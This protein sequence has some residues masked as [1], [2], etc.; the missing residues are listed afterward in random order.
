MVQVR[1]EVG[2]AVHKGLIVLPFRV[3]DVLPIK[4][5]EYFLS[6]Q[7]WLDAFPPPR[8]PH[9]QRLCA[10]VKAALAAPPTRAVRQPLD[11]PDALA[12]IAPATVSNATLGPAARPQCASPEQLH[13]LEVEL[14]RY[15]GPV[16][17][18]LV[19]HAAAS[20]SDLQQLSIRLSAELDSEQDRQKFM[21]A[22]R[23]LG[24]TPL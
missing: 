9:Y 6:S 15:I 24:A 10:F 2:R 3:E 8:E 19:R 5:L 11:A 16:A 7:H 23:V 22:C 17:K 13:Q 12:K 1:R 18:H 20:A 4:S 21:G 14:A